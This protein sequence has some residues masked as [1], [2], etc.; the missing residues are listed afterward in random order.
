MGNRCS[1]RRVSRRPMTECE[2]AHRFRQAALL[3]S[4][5]GVPLACLLKGA[6]DRP[7]RN[8]STLIQ[9]EVPACEDGGVS[10]VLFRQDEP[11]S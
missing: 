10:K 1:P 9:R 11:C 4:A 7:W 5:K 3:K 8:W 6:D 2:A